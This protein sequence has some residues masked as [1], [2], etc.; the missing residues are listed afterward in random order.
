MQFPLIKDDDDSSWFWNSNSC[1]PKDHTASINRHKFHMLFLTCLLCL[2]ISFLRSASRRGSTF[3]F[4]Q[5]NLTVENSAHEFVI[6][7]DFLRT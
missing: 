5:D 4:F 6:L 7:S 2:V 3:G 1:L